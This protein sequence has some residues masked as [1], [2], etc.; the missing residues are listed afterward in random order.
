MYYA[1]PAACGM[2][3]SS[4][5]HEAEARNTQKGQTSNQSRIHNEMTHNGKPSYILSIV[6][7]QSMQQG[8]KKTVAMRLL[9]FLASG[10]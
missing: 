6:L 9:M 2:Y 1:P 3:F 7:I 8:Y 10:L 4:L 5:I